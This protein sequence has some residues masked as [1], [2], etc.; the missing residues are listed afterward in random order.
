MFQIFHLQQKI[1][2]SEEYILKM[3]YGPDQTVFAPTIDFMLCI[4]V[5]RDSALKLACPTF[6]LTILVYT[7]LIPTK[8]L[9]W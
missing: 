3:D 9:N 6:R 1:P 7:S 8:I 2:H 4:Y 5:S